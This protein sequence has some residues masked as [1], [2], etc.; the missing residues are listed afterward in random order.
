[1][2][3]PSRHRRKPMNETIHA[4]ERPAPFSRRLLALVYELLVVLALLMVTV[5]ASLW[6]THGQLHDHAWWFRLLL[7]AVLEA[8]FVLSWMLG[9][10][11]LA[12]RAW[13]LYL[14]TDAGGTVDFTRAFLRFALLA[15]PLLLL[16]LVPMAGLLVGGLAPLAVWVV[17]LAVAAFD[18]RGRALHDILAGTW[19]AYRPAPSRDAGSTA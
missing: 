13:R 15:S 1:M 16:A 6:A 17:D 11:S 2:L 9:G 3:E 12:M 7:L 19:I 5:M 4:Q 8:Y 14:R 18:R 10:Q